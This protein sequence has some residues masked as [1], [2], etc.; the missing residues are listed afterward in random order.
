MNMKTQAWSDPGKPIWR[1]FNE[2]ER[3]TFRNYR[4]GNR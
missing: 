2:D 4:L 1:I 3:Y